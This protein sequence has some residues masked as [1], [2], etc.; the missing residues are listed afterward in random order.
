MKIFGKFI[1]ISLVITCPIFGLEEDLDTPLP[2][3]S[4]ETPPSTPNKAA[5]EEAPPTPPKKEA[6]EETQ[7]PNDLT[8]KSS[9]EDD[10][11]ADSLKDIP[12]I[13]DYTYT[14][15]EGLLKVNPLEPLHQVWRPIYLFYRDEMDI[16]L[17]LAYTTLYQR[18][19][20]GIG[21]E[22]AA[23]DDFDFYGLWT[24]CDK[25]KTL[26]PSSVGFN[27]ES[28]AKWTS[29]PPRQLAANIG[30]L[31]GTVNTFSR[32]DFSLIQL[33]WEYHLIRKKFGFRLG[34]LDQTDY[35]NLYT[36][37]S[38][39]FSFL[40]QGLTGDLTIGFPDNGLGAIV[41]YKPTQ[42][43][44]IFAGIGDMNAV[45]TSMCLDTFFSD[46]EYFTAFEFSYKPQVPCQGE[47]NYN[48]MIW[49]SDE[50]KKKHIP[51]SKGFAVSFEQEFRSGFTPFVRYGHSD[52]KNT[53]ITD[54]LAAGFGIITPFRRKDDEFGFGFIWAKPRKH[55]LSDQMMCESYYR[56]Q[57]THH[58]QISPDIEVIFNPSY[59]PRH[60]VIGVFS[61]RV[62]ATL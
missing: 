20:A 16:D 58:I 60:D 24:I 51:A 25:D 2:P 28:R 34:K 54:S 5:G 59:N 6:G 37:T 49:H 35:F 57:L 39:N 15:K 22:E 44:F 18:A 21:Y 42:E 47:G 32:E 23:G 29:I 56:L 10:I 13:I 31:W 40:N 14:E 55:G 50:V 53:G 61:L 36:F 1:A 46:H 9:S 26:H 17:A 45:K 11:L 48:I 62:R 30:S 7:K 19:T 3:V 41:G 33:W 4:E 8:P 27:F 38:S 12:D 52:G 43:T